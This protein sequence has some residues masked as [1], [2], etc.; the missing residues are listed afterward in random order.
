MQAYRNAQNL[1]TQIQRVARAMHVSAQ[2]VVALIIA[3][4]ARRR[5]AEATALIA[6]AYGAD[7]TL[8]RAGNVVRRRAGNAAR[9]ARS[10]A[11]RSVRGAASMAARSVRGAASAVRRRVR[12]SPRRSN[13]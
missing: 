9:G 8:S 4:L 6:L 1:Y 11:G 2:V 7:Y 3:D 12:P 5:P 13:N 10:L